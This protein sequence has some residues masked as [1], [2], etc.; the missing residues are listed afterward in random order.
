[1]TTAGKRNPANPQPLLQWSLA[2]S[3]FLSTPDYVDVMWRRRAGVRNRELAFRM[4]GAIPQ[5]MDLSG[6][7]EATQKA[8][9]IGRPRRSPHR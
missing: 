1:M 5:V 8:Y 3:E 6:E 7:T 9:G 4:E 2:T